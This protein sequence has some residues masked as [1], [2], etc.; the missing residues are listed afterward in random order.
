MH[1]TIV[2]YR[3]KQGRTEE[4][5]DLVRAVYAELAALEPEGFR[6]ATFILPDEVSFLHVAF[7][8]DG[9]H[10]PLPDLPAFARFT[11]DIGER[12]EDPPQTARGDALVGSYGL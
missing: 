11:Q 2:R 1:V 3:V 12:C 5:A 4:N 9:A 8:E 7:L 10:A 6:Y